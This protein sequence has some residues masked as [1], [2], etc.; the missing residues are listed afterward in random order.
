M[1]LEADFFTVAALK[2]NVS[3]LLTNFF[4][5]PPVERETS[6]SQSLLQP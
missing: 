3:N 1:I 5:H 6:A 2:E 4:K